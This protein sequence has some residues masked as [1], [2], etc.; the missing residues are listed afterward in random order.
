MGSAERRDRE[1]QQRRE[2]ILASAR[3][4]FDRNGY[5]ATTI[6][7]IVDSIELTKGAFY[8]HFSSKQEV[9]GILQFQNLE[10]LEGWFAEAVKSIDDPGEQLIRL[11]RTYLKYIQENLSPNHSM[12]FLLDDYRIDD[13]PDELRRL[14]RARFQRLFQY[15][16]DA[17][18]K[19]KTSGL[20]RPDIDTQKLTA[21]F[22]ATAAGV[23]A[24]SVKL[25]DL[26]PELDAE[27]VSEEFFKT[28]P[29]GLI[30]RE[31]R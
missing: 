2:E 17:F 18:E 31:N 25:A 6:D 16:F 5:D 28:I 8:H 24:M 12:Y 14:T 3:Q 26:M 9:L 22:W 29:Y 19:G 7:E 1:R 13:L 10:L 21:A 23:H 27:S 20:F 11:G 30:S 15:V 4:L